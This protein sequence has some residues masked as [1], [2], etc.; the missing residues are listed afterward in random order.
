MAHVP[1]QDKAPTNTDSDNEWDDEPIINRPASPIEEGR[2]L[3][4]YYGQDADWRTRK[5]EEIWEFSLADLEDSHDYI[6]WL[7]PLN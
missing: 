5:I 1:K 4:F 2:I 7:F 6:Q 3:P